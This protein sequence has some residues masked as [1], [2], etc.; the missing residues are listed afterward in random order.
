MKTPVAAWWRVRLDEKGDVCVDATL[1]WTW[2]VLVGKTSQP[3]TLPMN[4]WLSKVLDNRKINWIITNNYYYPIK[5]VYGCAVKRA[6][7]TSL[8][9]LFPIRVVTPAL[10]SFP[11]TPLAII[12]AQ[13]SSTKSK[14]TQ[15]TCTQHSPLSLPLFAFIL[16]LVPLTPWSMRSIRSLNLQSSLETSALC[17]RWRQTLSH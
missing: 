11:P 1:L 6:R 16:A 8:C 2:G 4:K 14:E 3:L 5:A 10:S 9:N 7:V 15:L 17:L 12:R 13:Q